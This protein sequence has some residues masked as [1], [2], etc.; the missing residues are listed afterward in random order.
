VNIKG[1]KAA[2]RFS[3][4]G[5]NISELSY[6]FL[7]KHPDIDIFVGINIG[8]EGLS[9]RCIKEDIDTGLLLAK[10]NGGGG[11]PRAS[12]CPIP[13]NIKREVLDMILE[14]LDPDAVEGSQKL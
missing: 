11:H 7:S 14:Y 2:V 1:L 10:P 12:G 9:F 8:G 5:M 6:Q 13:A 3:N 4:G